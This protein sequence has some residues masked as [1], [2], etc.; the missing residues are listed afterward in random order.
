MAGWAALS[1]FLVVVWALV[2]NEFWFRVL[3]IAGIYAIVVVPLD[4]LVGYMGYLPFGQAAFFGL[5]AYLV[6]NMTVLRFGLNFWVALVIAV[7]VTGVIGYLLAVP[8]FR[9]TGA[10]FAIA[11]LAVAQVALLMFDGWDWLTGGTFG[12]AGVPRPS[13]FGYAFVDN[14]RLFLLVALFFVLA[15]LSSW[16]VVRSRTGLVLRA[17]RQDEVLAEA[18]GLDITTTKRWVFAFAAGWAALAGGIF[19]SVQVAIAPAQF[20]VQ[21]SLLFIIILIL[22]GTRSLVGPAIGAVF[23]IWLEQAIQTFAEWNQLV[24][25][26]L[27]VLA[28]LFFKGGIWGVLRRLGTLFGDP[29]PPPRAGVTAGPHTAE[30]LAEPQAGAT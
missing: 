19:A 18:R 29:T 10:H 17:I 26:A 22:G 23:Y 7:A 30:G 9:L 28:V 25:G 20:T 21:I 13:L 24:L 11:T 6:G 15:A 27:L 2:D 16:L 1:V 12:I 4:L 8:M 14:S 3:V 5:G